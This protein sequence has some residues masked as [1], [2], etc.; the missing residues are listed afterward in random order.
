M[1][2]DAQELLLQADVARLSGHPDQAFA[3]LR[4]LLARHATDAQAPLAAFTLGR[5]LLDELKRPRDAAQAFAQVYRLAPNGALSQ[6][7]LAREVEAWSRAGESALAHE[8]ALRYVQSYPQGRKVNAVRH[9]GG[10]E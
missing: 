8:R 7:A 10:I 6:D 4:R 9:Y 3:P 1:R 5:V 2:D